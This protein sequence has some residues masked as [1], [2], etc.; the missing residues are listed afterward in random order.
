MNIIAE[1]PRNE[2]IRVNVKP[3]PKQETEQAPFIRF[4]IDLTQITDP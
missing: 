1:K 2:I 4:S 3:N